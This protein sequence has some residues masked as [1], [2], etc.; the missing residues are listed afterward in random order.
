MDVLVVPSTPTIY[1]HDEIAADPVRLNSNLGY[2]TNFVN[3]LDQAAVAAP[4][5]FR[6][7]GLPF[8]ITLIGPAFTDEALLGLADRYHRATNETEAPALDTG[9]CPPGCVAIAVVGAHLSG[10]PLN[11]QLTQRRARLLKTTSTEACYRFYAL[12][13]TE[14]LKPGLLREEGFAGPGIEVEVWAVPE[15]E[16]GSFVAA[17]PPPLAIGNARLKDGETVKC[18]LCE[19]YA[20]RGATEITQL[21]GWR[22]FLATQE[23]K[24]SV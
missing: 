20:L 4:A 23:L 1:T 22:A 18:F 16:F 13:G 11:W 10:Q 6:S 24:A 15:N 3:L 17:V 21:G 8:G 9:A 2:Y 12:P 7:N 14:P 5:G 19:P